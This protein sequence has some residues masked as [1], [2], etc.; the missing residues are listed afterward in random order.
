MC[1]FRLTY[2]F[3]KIIFQEF[4]TWELHLLQNEGQSSYNTV[5]KRTGIRNTSPVVHG[6]PEKKCES[7]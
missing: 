3:L 5:Q 2:S 4:N 7:F 6:L 1:T